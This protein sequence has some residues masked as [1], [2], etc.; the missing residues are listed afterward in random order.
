MDMNGDYRRKQ[1]RRTKPYNAQTA[2]LEALAKST[3]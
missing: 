2:L 3:G 1:P